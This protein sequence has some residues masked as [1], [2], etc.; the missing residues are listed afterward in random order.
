MTAPWRSLFDGASLD[1][2]FPAPRSYGSVYPG[3]PSVLGSGLGFPADYNERAEEHPAVWSVEDGA[4]VGRQ[5]PE[6]PGWGGYLVSEE[7]FGDFELELE[8][9]PDWPAD[10][11]VMIR[12]ARDTWEGL[13]ILV[14]HRRSGSIG[15]VYGN[16]IGGF[17]GVPFAVDALLDDAGR[18]VGLQEQDP[19]ESVEP[20]T[21]AKRAMLTRAGDAGE[22]LAAWRWRGWN[23][24]R[25]VCE[26]TP[27]HVTTWVNGVMVAEI[28]CA[29]FAYPG[30]DAEKV[31]STLGPRGHIAFE[32]HDNDPGMGEERWGRG[33]VCRWRDIRIRER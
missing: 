13:Q 29:S 26:G 20:I 3:G 12:R 1:G 9:R 4:I 5:D 7:S 14:D 31:W 16:G 22:F 18:P 17:H 32:V 23:S 8:M 10:T 11:G 2:W 19:A 24:L 28:D 30:Y 21:E 15:G 33:A 25:I 27:P 6:A